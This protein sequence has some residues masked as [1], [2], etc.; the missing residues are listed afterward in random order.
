[1]LRTIDRLYLWSAM[2]GLATAA[3]L[4][5]LGIAMQTRVRLP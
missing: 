3:V 5:E 2:I 1:M 4:I